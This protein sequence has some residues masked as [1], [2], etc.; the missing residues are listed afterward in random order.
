MTYHLTYSPRHGYV[1]NWLVAGPYT[2]AVKDLEQFQGP[3]FKLQ[4]ARQN[5]RK[6]SEIHEPPIEKGSF[7]VGEQELTWRYHRCLDDHFV[8]LST[9]YHTTHYLRSWAYCQVEAREAGE[10][11]LTLTSNGPADVW[12]NG[13]H[14]HRQEHFSHQDP[15]SVSFEATLQ[16]GWNEVLVRFEEVAARECPYVVALHVAGL[17][18]EAAIRVPTYIEHVETRQLLEETFEQAHTEL[19]VV[20]KGEEV[21]FHWADDLERRVHYCYQVQDQRNRIYLEG[22]LVAEAGATINAG[23]PSAQWEGDYYIVLRPLPEQYYIHNIRYERRIPVAVLDHAYS[24]Q[25]YGTYSERRREALQHA[26]EHELG[27]YSEIAKLEIGRWANVDDDVVLAAVER[28]NNREDCSDFYLVGILGMLYRYAG[29]STFPSTLRDPLEACVLNFKYWHDE[30]GADA[31][32]YTTENHS[33]LFHACEVLAG[34][35]YP[36]R[37]FGNAGETGE[38][39]REKG[40]RLALEW[41]RQRGT[42]GFSEWDSNCYF[43]EDLLALSHL[44]DLAESDE[45]RELAAVVMDKMLFTMAVNSFKG[46]FGSTHGRTYA[47]LI[48]GGRLEATSG[49]G[50][51]LWGL[52]VWNDHVRGTVALACS[53][54]ELPLMI[55]QIAA[56]TSEIW[57]KEQHPGVNKVTYRTADYMLCSAQD[58]HPGEKGYQQHVWQ[59]TLGPDAVV[60]VTHPPC[61]SAEGAHRPNFW[62][63]NYVLPRVAHWKDVLIA[64]HE[65]PEDDWMG[66]THAYFPVHAFDEYELRDGWA[67]ARAGEGYLALKAARGLDLVKS[68]PSAYRELRS[69]GP[70]NVWLCH[71]GRA[72]GDGSFGEFQEKVLALD[73]RLDGLSAECDTLR[74]ERI[75]FGWDGPF[76]VDGEEQPLSGY[77][78]YDGPFCVADLP[79]QQMD[80]GY[81]EYVVRLHFEPDH[82]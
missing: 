3:D 76:T 36:D 68:G 70:Q 62:H 4:I 44:H 51:L 45:L 1:H 38:W 24:T 69:Y 41:L 21:T 26:A 18:E 34:Q 55:A 2:T 16:E 33:I 57:H 47:A 28:I 80:I 29:R 43:E 9:F 74:G 73:V 20:Y 72:D 50:R 53:Q 35:R 17:G 23:Q 11:T 46:V 39:H 7:Q 75:A 27:L 61:A 65:L 56:D 5:Y 58:Y 52:G 71:M 25:P 40:E 19:D 54:Y 63:G 60:F 37:V 22:Q 48:K 31:M 64:I 67:F 13:Q 32:C 30:P 14:T 42:T 59:A 49:I 66:F 78:H 12:I 8:D 15:R 82:A 10:V 77:R 6:L 81:G 79:A